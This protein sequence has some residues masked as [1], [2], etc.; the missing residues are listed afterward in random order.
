MT[1]ST[2]EAQFEAPTQTMTDE[3]LVVKIGGGA[4]VNL[5]AIIAD[6]AQLVQQTNRPLVV[7]HGVSDEANRL[8]EQRG[9]PVQMLTSPS[10]HSS[11]YTNAE[12]RDVFVEA[13]HNVSRRVVELFS[14]FG[15][16]AQRVE[17]TVNGE[18][19][20]AVRAVVDGR[21]R[22]VRDDY[23]GSI[24]SVNARPI[25]DLL[26]DGIVPVLP[27]QAFSHHDGILN[28]DGDRAA[29]AVAAA[30]GADDLVILSN[31]RGLYRSYPDESS[32]V[33]EVRA[34]QMETALEDWAEGRM[35]R[36]V[37]GAQ[38]ALQGGVQ[39]VWIADGRVANPVQAALGGAGTVFTR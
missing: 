1:Y 26:A 39:R 12:T 18:R 8:C 21:V 28:V 11:R 24:S 30:L 34:A 15:V 16:A 37:L 7:V 20:K 36:K 31:V 22:V 9:V 17:R 29:A 2:A 27:P 19:K 5:E 4:G 10:G 23:T 13:A 3:V 38:E 35:K 32:F 14:M 6:L 25:R 33:H